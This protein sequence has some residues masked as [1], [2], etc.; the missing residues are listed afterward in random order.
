MWERG[1]G[2]DSGRV[3]RVRATRGLQAS[4]VPRR[5]WELLPRVV[6]EDVSLPLGAALV[7]LRMGKISVK[8]LLV[9][10][11]KTRVGSDL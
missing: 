11:E 9:R 5:N 1:H 3:S 4:L 2:P 7:D 8:T 6:L 10:M